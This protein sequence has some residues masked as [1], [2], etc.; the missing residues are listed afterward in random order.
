LKKLLVIHDIP[1]NHARHFTDLG[2]KYTEDT[3][4]LTKYP[5]DVGLVL[6]T[7]GADVSPQ[8][9]DKTP[10][11]RTFCSANRDSRELQLFDAAY[12]AGI[13]LVGICRGAQFLCVMAGGKLVQDVTGHQMC[14]HAVLA[15][16][17]NGKVKEL[18][19]AGDHHQM[20]YPWD[21]PTEEFEVLAYSPK[22]R[23]KHYA[24]DAETTVNIEEATRELRME[25]DVVF[26]PGINALAVQFHPEWM[27]YDEPAVS[28]VKELI[29]HYLLTESDYETNRTR[30]EVT[31]STSRG[32]RLHQRSS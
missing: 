26:Y 28:Y 32:L 29:T 25:P 5:E 1:R 4:L 14:R 7:G 21:L 23:S 3:A 20:Q 31:S 15:K 6:F 24:F 16:S 27:E 9:Y 11:P 8:L 10:H 19:V 2:L 13:P 22:P 12:S 18:I 17:P 30:K